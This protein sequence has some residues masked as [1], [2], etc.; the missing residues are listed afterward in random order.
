MVNSVVLLVN[1]FDLNESQIEDIRRTAE[2]GLK[3]AFCLSQESVK[4]SISQIF[5]LEESKTA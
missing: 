5:G 4:V 1:L 2:L 3:E